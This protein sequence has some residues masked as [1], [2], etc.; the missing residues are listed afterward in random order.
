MSAA[1]MIRRGGM[2][3]ALAAAMV[4]GA[5]LVQAL[6]QWQQ[7]EGDRA[8]LRHARYG[9]LDTAQWSRRLSAV[10][11]E[12]IATFELDEQ[13]RPQLLAALT[14]TLESLITEIERE[15]LPSR[16]PPP[17][18]DWMAQLQGALEQELRERLVDFD[19][20]RAQAPEYAE[21]LLT[22]FEGAEAEALIRAELLALL[23]AAT[24]TEVE[25]APGLAVL[26]E[27]YDCAAAAPCAAL[28]EGEV[29]ALRPAIEWR[30]GA[31]LGLTVVV[32]VLAA[33]GRD[34]RGG[35]DA[36]ALGAVVTMTLI[37]LLGALFTPMLAIEA[38]VDR[39]SLDVLGESV[40]FTDQ[41]LY[42]QSKSLLQVVEILIRA[43]GVD[44]WLVALLITLFSV[45]FPALK[46]LATLVYHRAAGAP[47]AA[48]VRFFALRSGKWS[49]ADV[50]VV[51][52]FMAYLGFDALVAN[53]LGTLDA[54]DATVL[55]TNGTALA[56]GFYLFLAF[57]LA[58]LV[59]SS[60]I[61]RPAFAPV[62]HDRRGEG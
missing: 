48:P 61:E 17:S 5:Q 57:V 4:F 31:L 22:A 54:T 6:G 23:T 47:V 34:R 18:N 32:F 45:V 9:M 2:V 53:Q 49:M 56:P 24:P 10:L 46:L 8:E 20:L 28:L 55:T 59:L 14:A 37:L 43:G 19:A 33:W 7:F 25:V 44:L 42:Y 29:V 11:A 50:L 15:L 12:R 58:N 36:F 13:R 40:V 52:L 62:D 51:A 26:L 3:L 41:V 27:R 35:L 60:L 30:L 39:L 1:L 21:R 16:P 38:R